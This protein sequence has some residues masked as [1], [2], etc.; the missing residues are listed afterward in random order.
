[1]R[2]RHLDHA[3]DTPVAE[4]GPRRS[5]TCSTAAIST[6][7]PPLLRE[8]RRDPHGPVAD[9]ILRLGRD[10]P[11]YGTS[12]LWR[13]WIEKRRGASAISVGPSLRQLRVARG[14]TQLEVAEQLGAT[15]PEVSKLERRGDVRLSTLRSYV[16]ALGGSLSVVARFEDGDVELPH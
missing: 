8:I 12:R 7:G 9:R 2:H 5:T 3:S 1:M 10:H 14:R 13:A 11:L 16:E 6:T 4:L 15:Q